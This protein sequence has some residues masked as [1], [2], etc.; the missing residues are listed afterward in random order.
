VSSLAILAGAVKGARVF[1]TDLGGSSSTFA[2][3]VETTQF[4]DGFLHISVFAA[5][6]LPGGHPHVIYGGVPDEFL[7]VAPSAGEAERQVLCVARLLP[8][9]GIN[10][11]IEGLPDGLR[12]KLIGRAYS[13]DYLSYLRGLVVGKNVEFATDADDAQLTQAY[14]TSLVTV[15]PSVYKDI[16]GNHYATPELLGLVLLESMAFGT[17]VICTDVA[18]MPE[19]VDEGVT[20]FVVPP[21]DPAALRQ[22][23]QYLAERPALAKQMG[24]QGREKVL[25][26][27]TWPGVVKRCLAAYE[28]QGFAA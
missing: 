14:R 17:P 20:G 6:M 7:D 11:L 10:Y 24:R 1:V 3:G 18:S 5:K 9:K 16:Y 26:Q 13:P 21:N 25:R 27:F 8:H 19:L 23:I 28:E 4:V 2:A 12:L 22:R 15:L